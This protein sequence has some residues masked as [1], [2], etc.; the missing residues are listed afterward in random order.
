MLGG[1]ERFVYKGQRQ[2]GHT[3]GSTV[4][5]T[6]ILERLHNNLIDRNAEEDDL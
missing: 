3:H 5:A 4:S 2:Q 6:A 1:M